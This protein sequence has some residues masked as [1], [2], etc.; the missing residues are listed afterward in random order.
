MIGVEYIVIGIIGAMESEVNG[1]KAS[2]ENAEIRKIASVEFCSGT[3]NGKEVVIAEAGVGKVNAAVTA[4]IMI[5]EYGTEAVINAGVAGGLNATLKVGDI[6]VADKVAEHD[7]DTTPFGDPPGFI[8]GLER[9]YME[10]D[11][12]ITQILKKTAE[13]LGVHT[14]VGTIVSG[15]QFICRKEQ[16][17]K[18]IGEFNA[19][20]A[21]ME[22]AAIGH[23]CAMNG[24][25]FGVIRAMSDCA[26]DDSI[27]DFPTF[28]LKAASRSVE[29]IKRAVSKMDH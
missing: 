14:I 15:D 19:D 26:N 20:A 10:C 11:E 23:V 5:L 2:V 16:R 13:E 27:V 21:E 24:V 8:T 28:E 18:L 1:L 25:R 7:M 29:I 3:L 6:V 22:G 4:Q 17:E 9:V 12:G